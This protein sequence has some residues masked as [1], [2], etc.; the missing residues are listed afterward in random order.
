M[1]TDTTPS[2]IGRHLGTLFIVG[3]SVA[4]ARSSAALLSVSI[5]LI[6]L[7]ARGRGKRQVAA[8][9]HTGTEAKVKR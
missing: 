1:I 2:R 4:V 3:Q 7:V 9:V 6:A 8:I 5:R